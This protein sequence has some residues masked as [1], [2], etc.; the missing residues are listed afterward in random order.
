MELAPDQRLRLETSRDQVVSVAEGVLYVVIGENEAVLTA[1]DSIA[2]AAGEQARA[3]NGG[4]ETA[5]VEVRGRRTL[6]LAA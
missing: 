1:G 3:W 4:D 6:R 2:I 5:R